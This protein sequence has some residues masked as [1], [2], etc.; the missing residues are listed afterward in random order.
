MSPIPQN[1]SGKSVGAEP[2]PE[3]STVDSAKKSAR[4][5]SQG[6]D[7]LMAMEDSKTDGKNISK[8]NN[9]QN[10]DASNNVDAPGTQRLQT[11]QEVTSRLAGYFGM[12][13]LVTEV[14]LKFLTAPLMDGFDKL[15]N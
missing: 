1:T 2:E 5:V 9:S 14:G 3:F 4:S 13:Y 15:S 10:G 11:V 6:T 7:D 8:M 12:V